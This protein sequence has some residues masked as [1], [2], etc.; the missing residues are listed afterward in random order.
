MSRVVDLEIATAENFE[1]IKFEEKFKIWVG[2]FGIVA[3]ELQTGIPLS[4]SDFEYPDGES[5]KQE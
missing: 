2:K 4:P 1:D 5:G 3:K